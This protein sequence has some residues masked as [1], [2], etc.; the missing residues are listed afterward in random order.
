MRD[1]PDLGMEGRGKFAIRIDVVT[2]LGP[3]LLPL[4]L[5]VYPLDFGVHTSM[6]LA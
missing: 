5:L 6:L 4:A 2:S 1:S 3:L